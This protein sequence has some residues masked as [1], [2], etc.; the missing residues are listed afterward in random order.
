MQRRLSI[1]TDVM[2][3]GVS[4]CEGTNVMSSVDISI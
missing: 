2:Q 4:C 3:H 1:F